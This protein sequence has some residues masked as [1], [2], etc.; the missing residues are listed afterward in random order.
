MGDAALWNWIQGERFDLVHFHMA[1]DLPMRTL[2][3]FA[4]SSLPYVVSLHDYY[5]LCPR[6]YMVDSA[7]EVCRR[8]DVSKCCR[9]IGAFDQID[10]LSKASRRLK[11]RLPRVSS[12]TAELRLREMKIFSWQRESS[13]SCFESYGRDIPGGCTWGPIHRGTDR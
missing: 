9:C 13:P 6:I 3:T 11:F 7:N 10:L 5:Y 12:T 1:L 8:I 2:R 4:G